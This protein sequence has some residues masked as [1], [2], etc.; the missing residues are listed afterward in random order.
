[1]ALVFLWDEASAIGGSHVSLALIVL[2]AV[3]GV[4]GCVFVVSA[5][6]FASFYDPAFTSALST[7]ATCFFFFFFFFFFVVLGC[8]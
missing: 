7:G 5:Y 2:T 3:A 8:R 1:M 4:V 6:P